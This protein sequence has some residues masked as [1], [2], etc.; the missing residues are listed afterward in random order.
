MI[1]YRDSYW[2]SLSSAEI[3]I[4][5]ASYQ[6]GHCTS[7]DSGWF[8][9]RV[10]VRKTWKSV[11]LSLKSVGP[12]EPTY[13]GDLWR[14]L[15]FYGREVP[16]QFGSFTTWDL[17]NNSLKS[18]ELKVGIVNRL[19][20]PPASTNKALLR[21]YFLG[22]GGGIGSVGPLDLHDLRVV[23]TRKKLAKPIFFVATRV[24]VCVCFQ[25]YAHTSHSV[26]GPVHRWREK[27]AIFWGTK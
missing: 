13:L 16:S 5:F 19:W 18:W 8:Y 10:N 21:P 20:S 11:T 24:C 3:Y 1:K 25:T 14:A 23:K 27:V 6:H 12:R 26:V 17:E 7:W 2:F 9:L 22:G 4:Y 15:F